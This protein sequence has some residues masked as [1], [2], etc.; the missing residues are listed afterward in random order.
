MTPAEAELAHAQSMARLKTELDEQI[1][2]WA[3][4]NQA[5]LGAPEPFWLT[6]SDFE[7]ERRRL[8]AGAEQAIRQGWRHVMTADQQMAETPDYEDD[9]V[10]CHDEHVAVIRQLQADALR[11]LNETERLVNRFNDARMDICNALRCGDRAEAELVANEFVCLPAIM[12]A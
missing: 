3:G 5:D 9:S 11:R 2:E 6:K 7:S 12:P 1:V 8:I 4:R 10:A